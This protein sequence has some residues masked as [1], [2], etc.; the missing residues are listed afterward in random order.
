MKSPLARV[1]ALTLLLAAALV[2]PLATPLAAQDPD[3]LDRLDQASRYQVESLIDS[4][5]V[6]GLPARALL[7]VAYEGI[8]KHADSRRIVRAVRDKLQGMRNAR[9]ALGPS[10][11]EAELS[12]AAD[13]LQ[14]GVP[15]QQ[16]ERF[17]SSRPGRP[18]A[19]ALVVLG[20]LITR[21]VP[22]EEASSTI[23]QLWQRG[24]GDADFYGLWRGVEQ[25]ILQGQSPGAAL[26]QRAREFPGRAPPGNLPPN[27]RP[28]TPSS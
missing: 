15:A 12:A 8:S 27:G 10:L 20:D 4:A 26:Q 13:V 25:D 22:V 24:A 17:R 6:L 14:A 21:G 9:N 1:G 2:A 7:S 11:S 19:Y 23:A 18:L 16:L 28:E 3:P 5:R